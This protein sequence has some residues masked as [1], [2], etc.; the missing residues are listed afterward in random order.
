VCTPAQLRSRRA[1]FPKAFD[2]P[3][4]D[5]FVDFLRPVGD[6]SVAF[7]AMNHFYAELHGELVKFLVGDKLADFFCGSTGD[8]LILNAPPSDIN[9]PLFGKM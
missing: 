3:G 4:V 9:Q 6:L 7:A 8:L 1:F 5:E 2:A